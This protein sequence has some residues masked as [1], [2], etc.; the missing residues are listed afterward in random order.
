MSSTYIIIDLRFEMELLQ[1]P[2]V[3]IENASYNPEVWPFITRCFSP[4]I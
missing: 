2:D 3:K 4:P 1:N